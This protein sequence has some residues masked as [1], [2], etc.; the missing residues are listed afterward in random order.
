MERAPVSI[1]KSLLWMGLSQL[2]LFFVQ[3]GGSVAV[4]R[5]LSPYEI[6]IFTVAAAVAAVVGVIQASGLNALLVR[7]PTL[8]PHIVSTTFTINALIA[9][10]VALAIWAMGSLGA[11]V[12]KEDGVHHALLLM[13]LMPIPGIF[14]FL[15]GTLLEREGRFKPIAAIK[16]IRIFVATAATLAFAWYGASYM[17]IVYGQLVSS[18]LGM[19]LFNV[20]GWRFVSLRTSLQDWRYVTKFGV[21]VLIVAGTNQIAGRVSEIVLGRVLGL[22]ALGLYTRAS[23]INALLW[24][25]LHTVAA[26]VLLIDFASALRQGVSLRT[27]YLRVVAII[28][29]V[30]WPAFTGLAILSGPFIY[31]VY[32][33]KWIAAALPLSLLAMSMVPAAA[34]AMNWELFVVRNATALQSRLEVQ[35]SAIGTLAFSVG[36]FFGLGYAAAG[37]CVESLYSFFVYRRHIERLTDTHE[38][39]YV[40][41][42]LRSAVAT[43]AAV[44]PALAL[45]VHAGWNPATPLTQVFT[46]IAIGIVLWLG[47]LWS[48]DHPIVQE[49]R[50]HLGRRGALSPQDAEA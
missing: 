27:R 35:R 14:E 39:D 47:V 2:G 31:A 38:S 13:A 21:Q 17:S 34:M 45:M 49:I 5:L 3:F 42:F 22:E 10:C 23:N 9:L 28:S 24:D 8:P 50:H 46:A 12:F 11:H 26:R 25:N 20:A 15:P 41:I 18:L 33:Q 7:E 48:F 44:M 6:G 43:L 29:A 36:A 1:R 37:R 32:G 30:L 4:A 16:A 40:P 19:A